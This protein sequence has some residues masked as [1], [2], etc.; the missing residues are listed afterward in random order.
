ME[1]KG[2]R[3]RMFTAGP[4][5]V[6]DAVKQSMIYPEMGHREPEFENLYVGIR[7]KLL[8]VFRAE[9]SKYSSFVIGGSGTAAM[10]SVISSVIHPGRKI[11][12]VNNGAFGDRMA[13][14]CKIHGIPAIQTGYE[15]GQYPDVKGIEAILHK[16]DVEAI[17]MVFMETSTGMVNPVK[18]VGELARKYGKT[19]IVDAVSGLAGD[20]LDVQESNID[21]CF[22][23]TNKGLSG[24]PA[25][26]FI[27]AR[28]EAIEKIKD[29]PQ[30]T[31]YLNL[32]SYYKYAEKSNQTP[33]T[34]QIPLFFMLNQAADELLQEGLD[35][36]HER[37]KQNSSL[38]RSRLKELGFRFQLPERYMSRVMTNVLI[39]KNYEYEEFHTQ[40][41]ER[42]YI[43]YP[44]KGPLDGKV[45]HIANVGTNTTKEV[46]EFCDAIAEIVKEKRVQY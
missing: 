6:S 42:D 33:F 13:E 9:P 46:S 5:N 3:F 32:L 36:R 29:I 16:N 27:C 22:S 41:K 43:V 25:I 44:G 17:S 15:W 45:M 7:R 14:I 37:Y 30:R 24:L 31:M 20:Y 35:N 23:N 28:K 1:K 39:P 34:P 18:E 21:F 12:V 11:L 10:E 2:R 40:L 38:L 8:E 26:S 4:V 19:F